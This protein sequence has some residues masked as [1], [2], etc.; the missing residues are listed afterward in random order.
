MLWVEGV[1]W[2]YSVVEHAAREN[3]PELIE[4]MLQTM[5]TEVRPADF[6]EGAQHA[7]EQLQ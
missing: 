3:Y 7:I 5:R 4:N 1:K 2:V 6:V